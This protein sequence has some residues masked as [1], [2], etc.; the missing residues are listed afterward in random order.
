VLAGV[1]GLVPLTIGVVNGRWGA[2]PEGF[3][4]LL[5][6]LDEQQTEG[7][8]RV[9]WLGDADVLPVAGREVRPGLAYGASDEGLP[10]IADRWLAAPAGP[11]EL[12]ATSVG[13]AE[14]RETSRLG[15]LLAPMG[16]RYVIVPEV[17][18]P[19]QDDEVFPQTELVAVLAEQLDLVRIDVDPDVHVFR[20]D[21]W[22]PER[23]A[24]AAGALAAIEGGSPDGYVE[25]ANQQQL[26]GG[27]PVLPE[28][29]RYAEYTGDLAAG[30]VYLA[31]AMSEDWRLD[32]GDD[33]AAA[34][35]VTVYGWANGFRVEAAGLARL[36]YETPTVYRVLLG[37]QVLLWVAAIAALRTAAIRRREAELV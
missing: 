6:F 36:R 33:P 25:L 30:D 22:V 37:V 20:N 15:R 12:I 9:V 14:A 31:Q 17:A 11:D 1:L 29:T 26:T 10:E 8:F 4:S 7:A 2:P 18:A 23:A 19:G 28:R 32:V 13:V 35:H 21:A 16:V 5:S 34:D 27:T 3:D 24:L